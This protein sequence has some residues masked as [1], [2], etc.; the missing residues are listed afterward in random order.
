MI[1]SAA[2]EA[3][4]AERHRNWDEGHGWH[5]PLVLSALSSNVERSRA[6]VELELQ[7][8]IIMVLWYIP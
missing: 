5:A 1:W 3:I 7:L 2:L 4:R 6:E 8:S